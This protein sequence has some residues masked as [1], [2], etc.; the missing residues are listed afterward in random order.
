VPTFT[1]EFNDIMEAQRPAPAFPK[2]DGTYNFPHLEERILAF[3]EEEKI[4]ERSL[5]KPAP[6]GSFVFYEGPPTAN[7]R[8]HMGHVLTRVVKDLFPRYRTMRGFRVHRK[9]GWDTH[10]LPVEIAIERKLGFEGKEAIEQYGVAAFNRE[11]YENVRLY[12]RE[13]A[14][15]S[16]R[17][18]FWLNYDEAYFTFTNPYI[19]SVWWLLGQLFERGL[20]YQGYKV[21]PYCPH[22]GTTLS[23]HEVA[24]GYKDVKDPSVYI[25]C[26][27]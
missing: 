24:Q 18:G 19:E 21:L 15:T 13:W 26:R 2:V 1:P 27:V 9:A 8:P 17:I 23:S 7:N 11:C 10:G 20:L 3:W 16:K 4:F 5:E 25:K 12:E 22:C 6:R 14:K